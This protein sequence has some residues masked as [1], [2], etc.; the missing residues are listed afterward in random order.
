[1]MSNSHT[2]TLTHSH[3]LE[4]AQ[5]LDLLDPLS[6]Y[7]SEFLMDDPHLIYLDGNSLGR[8][9]LR[10]RERLSQVV[11]HEWG[12]RLIRGWGEGWFTAPQRIG[13]KIAPLI[14]AQPD[15]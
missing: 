12:R 3:T 6:R 1:M 10:T 14:G 5:Q 9:P 7:R 13:A 11:D 15:E 4:D 2:H 8:L